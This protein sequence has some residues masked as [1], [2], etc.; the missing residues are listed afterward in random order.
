MQSGETS[1]PC[2]FD[3][4][5]TVRDAPGAASGLLTADM[6]GGCTDARPGRAAAAA[7]LIVAADPGAAPLCSLRRQVMSP[8]GQ[9][10]NA[11]SHGIAFEGFSLRLA[12]GITP[13]TPLHASIGIGLEAH[14][15]LP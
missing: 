13:N 14:V 6:C 8:K 12:N 10:G 15:R 11:M 5:L 3:N 4:S 2:L 1:K 7:L 9:G